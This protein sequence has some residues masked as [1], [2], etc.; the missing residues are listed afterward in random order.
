MSLAISFGEAFS[1]AIKRPEGNIVKVNGVARFDGL[2]WQDIGN[3]TNKLEGTIND[4]ACWDDRLILGGD[5]YLSGELAL[6]HLAYWQD[7]KWHTLE[8]PEK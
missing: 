7:A 2:V 8:I 1:I 6:K 4:M 3:D 5:F